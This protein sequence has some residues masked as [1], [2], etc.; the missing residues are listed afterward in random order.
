ML[1]CLL[2]IIGSIELFIN[3]LFDPNYR[4]RKS[5]I[6]RV[7]DELYFKRSCFRF[8]R[9]QLEIHGHQGFHLGFEAGA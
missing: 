2:L 1:L 3:E 4:N 6:A 5:S 9:K 7:K 8:C